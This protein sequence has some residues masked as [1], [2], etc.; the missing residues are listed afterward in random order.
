MRVCLALMLLVVFQ[1]AQAL[2]LPKNMQPDEPVRIRKH[3]FG[4]KYRQ[5]DDSRPL[6]IGSVQKVV[7][8]YPEARPDVLASKVWLYAGAS[9][10]GLGGFLAGYSVVR[11]IRGGELNKPMLYS[12]AGLIAVSVLFSKLSEIYLIRA[13]EKYNAILPA[14]VGMDWEYGP[15]RSSLALQVRF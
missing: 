7:E 2:E 13:V 10:G 5:G 14:K 8:R 15:E 9:A 4:P 3:F 6:K 11:D 1:A 12:G